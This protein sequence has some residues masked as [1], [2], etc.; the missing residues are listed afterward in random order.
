MKKFISVFL[1][2]MVGVGDSNTNSLKIRETIDLLLS[3]LGII[4]YHFARSKNGLSIMYSSEEIGFFNSNYA[5]VNLE[6]IQKLT[7]FVSPVISEFE[8]LSKEDLTFTSH[9]DVD[10]GEIIEYVRNINPLISRVE[11]VTEFISDS[12]RKVSFRY[13]SSYPQEM[14]KIREE[15]ITNTHKK[16]GVEF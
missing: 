8:N 6:K 13:Y 10:N 14:K 9:I 1:G 5:E 7:S 2:M 3:N 4:N 15:I 11:Y 16:Y 12:K